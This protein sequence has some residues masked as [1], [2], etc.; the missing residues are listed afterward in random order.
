MTGEGVSGPNPQLASGE[1]A[2]T[3]ITAEQRSHMVMKTVEA[4]LA[5][6]EVVFVNLSSTEGVENEWPLMSYLMSPH[7]WPEKDMLRKR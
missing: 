7:G 3:S 5:E 1:G 4:A 6:K 2:N